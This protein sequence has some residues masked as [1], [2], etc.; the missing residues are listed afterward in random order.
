MARIQF[1]DKGVDD[2]NNWRK[3][4]VKSLN[5]LATIIQGSV[6]DGID[7]LDTRVENLEAATALLNTVVNTTSESPD[8]ELS[9]GETAVINIT[10]AS[11]PLNI[12]VEDGVY[13]LTFE[14]DQSTFG[15]DREVTLEI[16]NTTYVGEFVA[17]R[18]SASTGYATDEVDTSDA[19]LDAHHMV[20]GLAGANTARPYR[21]D[22]RLVISGQRST[23]FSDYFGTSTS[24][25]QGSIRSLRNATPTHTSLGTLNAGEVVTGTAYVQ[26]IA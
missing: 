23:L 3:K 13:S 7:G 22:A 25:I 26:R 21:I 2:D 12:A 17:S 6:T 19:T 1:F 4:L 20:A 15:A 5:A 9:V 11:T 8:Y 18:F 24:R 10:A 16:N 14:F